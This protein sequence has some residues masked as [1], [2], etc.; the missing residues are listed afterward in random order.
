MKLNI[1][2]SIQ[3]EDQLPGAEFPRNMAL[4]HVRNVGIRLNTCPIFRGH[5]K[6]RVRAADRCTTMGFCPPPVQSRNGSPHSGGILDLVASACG[7][8]GP[9]L[10]AARSRQRVV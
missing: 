5:L 7:V 6:Q 10:A 8:T 3:Y 1:K 9:V 4:M 2:T